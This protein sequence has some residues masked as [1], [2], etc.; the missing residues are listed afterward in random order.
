MR[1][2]W[3]VEHHNNHAPD[4]AICAAAGIKILKNYEHYRPDTT[5]IEKYRNLL[6]RA[7]AAGRGGLVIIH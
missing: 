5:S 3:I 1:T 6:H 4:A 2:T 7:P